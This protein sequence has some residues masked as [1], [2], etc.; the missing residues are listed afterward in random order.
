M[1]PDQLE[2][3]LL[4]SY[5]G[6]NPIRACGER[7][8]FYNPVGLLKRGVYF[9]TVREA[10]GPNDRAS[11]LDRAGIFRLNIGIGKVAYRNHFGETPARPPKGGVVALG[12]DFTE[13]DTLP[14]P[15]PGIRLDGLGGDSCAR[16]S[17]G[18]AP[19]RCHG[20]TP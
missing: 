19:G 17:R 15:P 4:A 16:R 10:D 9:A 13:L 3:S 6:V 14:P 11:N 2:S 18:A 7:S 5:G 1:S 12:V 20:G 8:Y